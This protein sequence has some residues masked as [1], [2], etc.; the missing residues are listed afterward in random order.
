MS[1]GVGSLVDGVCEQ[2]EMFRGL[3]FGDVTCRKLGVR[4]S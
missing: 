1:N 3:G 2:D 4:L